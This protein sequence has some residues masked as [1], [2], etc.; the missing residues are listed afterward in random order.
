MMEL[1]ERLSLLREREA[2]CY[3]LCYYLLLNEEQACKAAEEALY[4]LFQC[5][6]YF[7]SDVSAKEAMLRKASLKS[8]LRI[9]MRTGSCSL[10]LN[11]KEQ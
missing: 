9:Q 8:A 7:T 2:D 1:Q 10:H 4:D 3:S 6:D 5:D 11:L